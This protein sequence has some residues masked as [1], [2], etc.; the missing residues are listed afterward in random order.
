[1]RRPPPL[2]WTFRIR[3]PYLPYP[4][5]KTLFPIYRC[6]QFSYHSC[7]CCRFREPASRGLQ[8]FV[9]RLT[10]T[11]SQCMDAHPIRA[12]SLPTIDVVGSI[13]RVNTQGMFISCS[14]EPV[15][16]MRMP[17]LIFRMVCLSSKNAI[18]VIIPHLL[19]S[20]TVR[21]VSTAFSRIICSTYIASN[22]HV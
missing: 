3:S 4:F 8:T 11:M 16:S 6:C 14:L 5:H 10:C 2:P 9:I 17:F 13:S 12:L 20:H 18:R 19:S 22:M 7:Y 15:P 1:M 21:K